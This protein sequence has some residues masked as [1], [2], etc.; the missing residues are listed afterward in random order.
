MNSTK[1]R[2]YKAR[3]ARRARV[4]KTALAGGICALCLMAAQPAMSA[5]VGRDII[6]PHEY[7]LPTPG[8]EPFN[9]FVQY[10]NYGLDGEVWNESG[11]RV[12]TQPTNTF[13]GLSKYVHFWTP[14]WAP[15]I[16]LAYE[17]LIPEVSIRQEPH[18]GTPGVTA[19]GFGDLITGAAIWF[20]P[21]DTDNVKF[22]L[23]YDFLITVPVGDVEVGGGDRWNINSAVLYN[24][25]YYKWNLTGDFGLVTPLTESTATDSR[26]GTVYYTDHVLSY[27]VAA[28]AQPFV[29][30]T[31]EYVASTDNDVTNVTTPSGHE[32]V[33]SAGLYLPFGLKSFTLRY[34]RGVSGESHKATNEIGFRFIYVFGI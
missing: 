28:H 17:V 1:A 26:P 33:L 5:G 24:L 20:N 19:S 29:G 2:V 7:D 14:D 8:F 34:S 18:N 32:T 10:A 22:T 15:S 21:V 13:I 12:E 30:L 23:G 27:A 31:Y 9:V 3:T 6:G 11:D 4:L 16:G 25:N